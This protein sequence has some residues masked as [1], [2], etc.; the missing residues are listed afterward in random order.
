M[1]C[2]LL[3][4]ICF[5]SLKSKDGQQS[6][7]GKKD[8][9]VPNVRSFKDHSQR[10]AELRKQR[11]RTDLYCN[12]ICTDLYSTKSKGHMLVL[13]SFIYKKKS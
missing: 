10:Q 1:H 13:K 3:T 9:G 12:L 2:L 6:H 11:V 5:S 4:V 8:P 7:G